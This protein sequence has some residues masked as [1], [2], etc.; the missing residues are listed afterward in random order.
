MSES[1]E[2]TQVTPKTEPVP[3]QKTGDTDAYASALRSITAERDALAS[4]LKAREKTIGEL[5]AERDSV[6]GQFEALSRQ[7]REGA[8][9]ER[10]ARDL[11]GADKMALRGV[12]AVLGEGGK[13]DRHPPAEQLEATAKAA[14]ELIK[15]EAP[16]LIRPAVSAGGT[17]GVP[18]RTAAPRPR[19]PF[20]LQ[21]R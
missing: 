17:N 11:P 18:S 20:D 13:L 9:L 8:L 1:T 21:R 15:T 12:V 3:Q 10:L 2:Q 14:L 5:T 19:S 7:A 6:K 16:S 4:E